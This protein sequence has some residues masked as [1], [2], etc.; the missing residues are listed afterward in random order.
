MDVLFKDP[1]EKNKN[2]E[3]T[4]TPV[5]VTCR[6]YGDTGDPR[7]FPDIQTE[8][9]KDKL[10]QL[11]ST[12]E[13]IKKLA[14]S[15]N[16]HG[17]DNPILAT[18]ISVIVESSVLISNQSFDVNLV[19]NLYQAVSSG[20]AELR[21]GRGVVFWFQPTPEQSNGYNDEDI[22]KGPTCCFVDPDKYDEHFWDTAT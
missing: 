10:D 21:V 8:A 15:Y 17:K 4:L 7:G 22:K 5:E 9:V 13:V 6:R 11:R 20:N 3:I 18:A 14:S 12:Y 19:S 1:N 16:D 2:V